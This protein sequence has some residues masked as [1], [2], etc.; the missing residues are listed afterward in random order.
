MS[1][2]IRTFL[3]SYALDIREVE[4]CLS[5]AIFGV[6]IRAHYSQPLVF[7]VLP[8]LFVVQGGCTTPRLAVCVAFALVLYGPFLFS[9]VLVHELSYALAAAR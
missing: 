6:H 7:I 9:T 8:L 5:R 1:A 2:L 3:L 4:H